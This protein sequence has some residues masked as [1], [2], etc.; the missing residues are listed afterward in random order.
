MTLV[1]ALAAALAAA[2][3]APTATPVPD[4]CGSILSIVTRPSVTTDVCTVRPHKVDLETGYTASTTTGSGGGVTVQ[5]PQAFLRI[6]SGDPHLEYDV[7]PPSSVQ[8]TV[9][10]ARIGGTSDTALGVKDELGYSSNALWGLSAQV[11]LPTGSRAFTAGAAQYAL[12]GNWSYTLSPVFSLAGTLGF[13]Q[14]AGY[15][16]SG[17]VQHAF[18][19]IPSLDLSATLSSNDEAFAEYAYFS[20]AGIG[21]PPRSLIDAGFIHD[22]SP[23]VQIDLEY[24]TQP[25]VIDGQRMHYVGAGLSFMN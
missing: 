1:L 14:I 12:D 19:F 15:A 2:S 13:N 20:R 10:T 18:A 24:G 17:T 9:G 11:T 4:P 22:L 7:T 21:L 8:S 23:H 16:A 3:P 5:Y 6:G 25:T